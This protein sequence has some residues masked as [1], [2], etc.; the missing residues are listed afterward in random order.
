[1]RRLREYSK[2][3]REARVVGLMLRMFCEAKHG[4][5]GRATAWS[6]PR[7]VAWLRHILG[8]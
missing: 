8:A 5:H 1:M 7:P 4:R 3:D 6:S 2:T